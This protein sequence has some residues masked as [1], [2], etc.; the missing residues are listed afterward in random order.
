M[1]GYFDIA[2]KQNKVQELEKITQQND[3]WQNQE[4]AKDVNTKL[5]NL[6]KN[7]KVWQKLQ[8]ELHETEEFLNLNEG[9][10]SDDSE[11]LKYLGEQVL[12]IEKICN[13]LEFFTLFSEKYDEHDVH[14]SFFLVQEEQ[15]HKIGLICCKE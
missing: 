2:D 4:F 5:N 1:G 10:N 13:E 14:L 9:P 6:Q 8:L 11:I 7:L 12:K 15:M 3:F